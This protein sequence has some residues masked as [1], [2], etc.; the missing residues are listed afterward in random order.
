VDVITCGDALWISCGTWLG[1]WSGAIG[2]FVGALMAAGVALLVV[3][4]TNKHQSQLASDA[5]ALQ[6]A[7]M[8]QQLKEL[9]DEA[10]L[11]RKLQSISDL[12]AAAGDTE[13]R[14]TQ[15]VELIEECRVQMYSAALRWIMND[16]RNH[17]L[18][19]I[20]RWPHHIS[21]LS[22]KVLNA[23]ARSEDSAQAER[24][25]SDAITMLQLCCT[26][27]GTRSRAEKQI[28]ELLNSARLHPEKARKIMEGEEK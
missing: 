24:E 11:A 8:Q 13:R 10:A 9:R 19:E 22:L 6:E 14:S 2:A 16:P 17:E 1:F 25:L 12:L 18:D 15:S 27:L 7:S 4:L 23:R 5:R 20:L 3:W 21:V 28:I 26:Q